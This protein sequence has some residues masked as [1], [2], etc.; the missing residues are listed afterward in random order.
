MYLHLHPIVS[1]SLSL[2]HRFP[3]SISYLS[4]FT[5]SLL[6]LPVPTTLYFLS[7]TQ[8]MDLHNLIDR[9]GVQDLTFAS[10]RP[11]VWAFEDEF[12]P[13]KPVHTKVCA[14]GHWRPH[15]D[16][17]LRELVAQF[18]PQNWNLIAEKLQGRS[19]NS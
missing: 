16:A 12:G 17:R 13:S 10:P 5:L 18:G 14:R 2:S 6:S 9:N 19:G 15:E 3:R 11:G 8:K 4:H 7:V 1:S